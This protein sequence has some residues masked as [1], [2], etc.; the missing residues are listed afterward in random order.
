[1]S[2]GYT[3]SHTQPGKGDAYDRDYQTSI[4]LTYLWEKE[5]KL[6]V[7]LICRERLRHG[8]DEPFGYLDFACGTARVLSALEGYASRA[9]GLDVSSEMLRAAQHKVSSAELVLGDF[10]EDPDIVRGKFH[11]VTAFRFFPNADPGLREKAAAYLSER[12]ARG[13]LLVVNNHQNSTSLLCV[14]GRLVGKRW[15]W[16]PM[17]TRHLIDL[18][19]GVGFELV[20]RRSYGVLPGT[21]RRPYL[22][23]WIHA[24]VDEA[25]NNLGLRNFGQDVILWFRR[26]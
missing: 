24:L 5:R 14:L 6:L 11:F 16:T 9:V 19:T 21:A 22:P 1:M 8:A 23:T 26:R 25:C 12:T 4:F 15:P 17:R 20:G 3:L 18:L 10:V 2:S 7:D 13:G